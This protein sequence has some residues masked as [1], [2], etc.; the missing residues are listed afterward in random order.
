MIAESGSPL[1]MYSFIENPKEYAIQLAQA[2][3]PDV[4]SEANSEEIRD[5]LVNLDGQTIDN[6]SRATA[7]ASLDP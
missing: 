3:N 1:N 7:I 4:S 6:Y 2:I 5:F